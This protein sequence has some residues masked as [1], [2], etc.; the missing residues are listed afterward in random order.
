MQM[1]L[2]NEIKKLF[3]EAVK[4]NGYALKYADKILQQD[5]EILRAVRKNR[6]GGVRQNRL[7]AVRKNRFTKR[8][9]IKDS[10]CRWI[11]NSYL[12]Y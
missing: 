3:F 11:T 10:G 7:G 12:V 1:N 6:L 4:Q 5:K 2:S 9:N 8:K